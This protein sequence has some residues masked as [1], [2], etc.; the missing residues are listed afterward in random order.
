MGSNLV[1]SCHIV[2]QG[3]KGL[4]SFREPPFCGPSN[5]SLLSLILL[6]TQRVSQ[7]VTV[8]VV[9]EVFRRLGAPCSTL[10]GPYKGALE[11]PGLLPALSVRFETAAPLPRVTTSTVKLET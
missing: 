11:G 3:K 8:V 2:S 9:A 7:E 6:K 10:P 1:L 5:R 4:W